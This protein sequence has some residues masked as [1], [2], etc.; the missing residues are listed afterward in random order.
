MKR[1]KK[2]I[3][4][5]I[6]TKLIIIFMLIFF[7]TFSLLNNYY[8]KVNP[9]IIEIVDIKLEKIMK[10]FL[11][12]KIGYGILKDNVLDN[13]LIINKNKEGEI[14]YADYNLEQAYYVLDLIS[15]ELIKG[16]NDLEKGQYVIDDNFILPSDHGLILKLPLFVNSDN[17]LLVN[18]GPKIYV[19]INFVGSILTNIKSKITNY[20]LNNALVEIYVTIE[21][22]HEIITPVV[23]KEEK[24]YYDV[25]ISSQVINGR[26]PEFYGGI[27][28]NKSNL[29]INETSS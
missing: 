13:I 20:G 10:L 8:K 17:I 22:M 2:R 26:V 14:L 28:E 18:F 1:I 21:I 23:K 15:N 12:G 6:S 16:I 24:I 7:L 9:K 27:L 4:L 29:E 19:K 25:L 3:K 5:K 11:S